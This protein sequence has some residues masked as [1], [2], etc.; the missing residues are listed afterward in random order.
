M[1]LWERKARLAHGFA[2]TL[3]LGT[4]I[5]CSVSCDHRDVLI[6]RRK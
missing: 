1:T 3:S 6:A 4:K 5:A 2:S